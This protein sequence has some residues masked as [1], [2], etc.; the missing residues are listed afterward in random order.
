MSER[1]LGLVLDGIFEKF[2][3]NDN[4]EISMETTLTELSPDKLKNLSRHGL[5]RISIGVQTFNDRGRKIMGRFGDGEFAQNRIKYYLDLGFENVNIDLIY[6][7]PYQSLEDLDEDMEI[8]A[9]LNIAGFS[10]YSFIL[11]EESRMAKKIDERAYKEKMDIKRDIEFYKNVVC[12]AEKAGYE[13]YEITKM[14]RPGRDQYKYISLINQGKDMLPIGGG[15]GGTISG[16]AIMNDIDLGQYEESLKNL[17]DRK[18]PVFNHDYARKNKAIKKIQFGFIDLE[19][20]QGKDQALAEDYGKSL[21]DD[22]MAQ[23]QGNKFI[24]NNTGRYWANNISEEFSSL[25]LNNF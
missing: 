18:Y 22:G 16:A 11:M 14:V 10:M 3:I 2:N 7:Y 9:N 13:F 6:N 21:I 8:I 25:I 19:D 20:L 24:L 12:Q 5:N 23:R 4:A 15:A 1:D 17:L